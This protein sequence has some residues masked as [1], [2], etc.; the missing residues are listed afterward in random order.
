MK[1]NPALKPVNNEDPENE[2][3]N[4]IDE[5]NIKEPEVMQ[6]HLD[7]PVTMYK[8]NQTEETE[9]VTTLPI[10]DALY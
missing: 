10:V 8:D 6:I 2:T 9:N 3:K 1:H 5:P 4:T 7:E